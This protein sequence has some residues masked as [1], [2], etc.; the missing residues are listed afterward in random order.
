[1]L[2]KIKCYITIFFID[3]TK[4]IKI[5]GLFLGSNQDYTDDV[6]TNKETSITK[7]KPI[8]SSGMC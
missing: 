8:N 2:L 6:Y 3:I 4:V 7:P 5:H 1:M